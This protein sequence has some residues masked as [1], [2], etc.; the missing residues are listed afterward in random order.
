MIWSRYIETGDWVRSTRTLRVTLTDHLQGGRAGIPA[1]TDG[2]VID[3]S[4][5]RIRVEF[6]TGWGPCTATISPSD[7]RV[8]RRAGG[9]DAFRRRAHTRMLVR[10]GLLI[11]LM[12]PFLYFA[13]WYLLHYRTFDGF[14][15]ALATQSIASFGD[16]LSMAIEH[17][18]QTVIYASVLALISRFTF[19]KRHQR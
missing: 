8:T 15:P 13:G 1:G 6:D 17:P 3:R 4:G 2:L 12:M 16:W 5:R 10:L 18:V 14:V 9:V 19:G 7:C 11:A